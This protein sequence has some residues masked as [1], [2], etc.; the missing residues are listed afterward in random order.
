[1][2]YTELPPELP[3]SNSPVI[4]TATGHMTP[5][6]RQFLIRLIR[7]IARGFAAL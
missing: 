2:P 5:E 1:M 7:W 6:W 4:D 3:D